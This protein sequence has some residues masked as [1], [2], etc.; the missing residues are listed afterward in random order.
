MTFF[1]QLILV[2]CWWPC[3]YLKQPLRLL[4]HGSSVFC[5]KCV[6]KLSSNRIENLRRQVG[7]S[8]WI[9]L[10]IY[11]FLSDLNIKRETDVVRQQSL[12]P[13]VGTKKST[14][15]IWDS[16]LENRLRYTGEGASWSILWLSI[17]Q[18]PPEAVCLTVCLTWSLAFEQ[19][20][21][22]WEKE[23]G[24]FLIF[25]ETFTNFKIWSQLIIQSLIDNWWRS[26]GKWMLWK[27]NYNS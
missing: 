26:L 19:W 20:Q 1:I 2:V 24:E 10:M 27:Y 13:P 18:S 15:D 7:Q 17:N 21:A 8:K 23:K 6:T 11:C 22:D 4:S 16:S 25:L 12:S 3:W 5:L 9:R 14:S